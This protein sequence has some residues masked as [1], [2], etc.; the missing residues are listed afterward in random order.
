MQ[1]LNALGSSKSQAAFVRNSAIYIV[2]PHVLLG[3]P[4]PTA[5]S[6]SAIAAASAQTDLAARASAAGVGSLWGRRAVP[7]VMPEHRGVD[8]NTPFDLRVA[9]VVLRERLHL[10]DEL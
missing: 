4:A 3:E 1:G 5:D 9:E 2:R 8:V 6:S 7:Y 10:R